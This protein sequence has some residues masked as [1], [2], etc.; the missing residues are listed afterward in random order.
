LLSSFVIID[1]SFVVGVLIRDQD[2]RILGSVGVSGAAADEDEYIA[3]QGVALTV[4][5]R[6]CKTEPNQHS[7]TTLKAKL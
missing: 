7:C 6:T 1:V 5:L 3:L 4:G 2:G